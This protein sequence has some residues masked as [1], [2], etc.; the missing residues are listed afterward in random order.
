MRSSHKTIKHSLDIL[1]SP[2]TLRPDKV[3]IT[4]AV[5]KCQQIRASKAAVEPR[6]GN[7][8][9]RSRV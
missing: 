4:R 3:N 1:R 8:P 9:Y 5:A 2:V 7:D 6:N